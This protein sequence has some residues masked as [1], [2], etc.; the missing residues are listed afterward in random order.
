MSENYRKVS[1]IDIF[2]IVQEAFLEQKEP[3]V[4]FCVHAEDES[5]CW[6]VVEWNGFIILNSNILY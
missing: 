3:H 4:K 1:I 2:K 5:R 6:M